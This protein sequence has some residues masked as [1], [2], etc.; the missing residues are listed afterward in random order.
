MKT[1]SAHLPHAA[2]FTTWF[3]DFLRQELAPYPG[4]GAT[5]ARMVIAATISAI[6]VVTFRIPGG[7]IGVLCAFVLSREDLLA[8]AKAAF[9]F[10]AAFTMAALFIPI[11]ARFFA[12]IPLTHFLWEGI[13][14][15]VIFFLLR[16]LTNFAMATGLSLVAT[17]VLAIWYLPGPAAKNVAL[18]LWQVAAAAVGAGVTL[19]VEAV[20][21]ALHK[22]DEV[23]SGVDARLQQ[24]EAL[25]QSYA[26]GAAPTEENTQLLARYAVVGMGAIRRHIARTADEPV[27]RMRMSA[28]VSLTGR[29]TD[30]AA[31]LANTVTRFEEAER[32]RTQKLAQQIAEIRACLNYKKQPVLR[33]APV[34]G[35]GATPLLTELEAMIS[36]IPSVLSGATSP[37]PRLNVLETPVSSDRIFVE[38]AFHNPEHL[39][40]A[41]SGTLAAMLCYVFYVALAWPSLA[42]SVTTCVLTGLTNIGASRQKQVLRLAGALL[43]GL[44][45]GMGAQV[46]VLPFIDSILGFAMLMAVVSTVAAWVS[47]SSSR[48][49]YAGVQIALAF[50]LI[51]LSEFTIQ[52]SL[53]VA[54]DR[55]I[56]VLLGTFMMWLVFERFYPRPAV[57][58]MIRV[59]IRNLRLMAELILTTPTNGNTES[60]VQIRR[61]RDQIYRYFGEVNA[62]SD[63]VPFETGAKRAGDMAARDRIRRWQASL[64]TFYLLEAPLLQFRIFSKEG[65]LAR[66][67]AVLENQ[68]RDECAHTFLRIAQTLEDQL[69]Q[70][71]L[72][73]EKPARLLESLDTSGEVDELNFSEREKALLRMTRTIASLVDRVQAEV[74]SEPLYST[75]G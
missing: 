33:E 72:K 69:N 73:P 1:A 23:Q 57:D 51:H 38:D 62:Q 46:F 34:A 24:I 60:I 31:A 13:S 43:G 35:P 22:Q 29:S 11:G 25:M 67:F 9:V 45:F 64:R 74:T 3:P 16:T 5:V 17:N 2:R 14:I 20:F 47:T 15:F 6:L 32:L 28:L 70:K 10:I 39:R 40:Y 54:R 48:L 55:L 56:G 37:D 49:S 52:T 8:T 18:T 27:H 4:R 36:L 53:T 65:E 75:E 19:T 68:F 30:F 50:Y 12:S 21:H 63:A 66:P 7:A 44:V 42:T 71:P 41:L 59:F 58:Q 61:Q 26:K